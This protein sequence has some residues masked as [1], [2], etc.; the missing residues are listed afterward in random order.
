MTKTNL[1]EAYKDFTE[2]ATTDLI[3]PVQQQKTDKEAPAPRAPEVHIMGLADFSAAKKKAPYVFHQIITAKDQWIPGQPRPDSRATVRSVAA[4]YHQNNQE[5]QLALLELFERIRIALLTK[6]VIGKQFRLD[7]KA[8]VEYL[9]YPDNIPPF[10]AGEMI[11]VWKLP[12]VEREVIY[13]KQ[14]YSNIRSSGPGGHDLQSHHC[15]GGHYGPQ[16]Q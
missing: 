1:L 6:G 9:I 12:P 2:E 4:V 16:E 11:T 14:G 5:G 10:Y 15:E 8:G 3:L 7:Y 13:G